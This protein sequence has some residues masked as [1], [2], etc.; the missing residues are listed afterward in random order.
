MVPSFYE[1][2]GLVALEAMACGTPVVASEVGGL[3]FLVQDGE[4]GYTVPVDEPQKLADRLNLLLNNHALRKKIGQQ[5]AAFAKHYSWEN[6]ST[7]I[8]EL[9]AEVLS[10]WNEDRQVL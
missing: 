1:S 4:T 9:Y 2:F 8:I 10:D 5:A 3:A 6:I 7:R